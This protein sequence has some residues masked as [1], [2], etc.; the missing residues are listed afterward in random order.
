M[1]TFSIRIDDEIKR[2]L[3]EAAAA[4]GTSVSRVVREALAQKIEDLED[5]LTATSRLAKPFDSVAKDDVWKGLK[6]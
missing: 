5:Y 2:R 4:N 3:E 1:A 6:L